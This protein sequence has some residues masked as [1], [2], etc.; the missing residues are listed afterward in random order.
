MTRPVSGLTAELYR[1][2]CFAVCY[3]A[4]SLHDGTRNAVKHVSKIPFS[5]LEKETL[6]VLHP[7]FF[8]AS[9]LYN[10]IAR[11]EAKAMKTKKFILIAWKRFFP[12]VCARIFPLCFVF[13][14]TLN[15][16]FFY[17]GFAYKDNIVRTYGFIAGNLFFAV[18]CGLALLSVLRR[19]RPP[20]HVWLLLGLVLA[21]YA[22]CFTVGFLQL[23]F[24]GFLLEYARDFIVFALPAFFAGIYGALER[25]ERTFLQT[26][27]S[28]SFLVLPGALIYANSVIFNC[29]PWQYNSYLGILG[30]MVVAYTFMPYLLAL[31]LRFAAGDPFSWRGK[32]LCHPQRVRGLMIA[33]LWVAII[34]TATRGAFVSILLFCLTLCLSRL[35]HRDR[36]KPA[37]WVSLAM[38]GILFFNL[39]IY[40]PPGLYRLGSTNMFLN[41]LAQ[42]ELVTSEREDP[43]VKEYIDDL[44]SVDGRIQ[45]ANREDPTDTEPGREEDSIADRNFRIGSRGTLFKLALLEFKKSPITGMGPGSYSLKYGMYPHSVFL[46]LLCE[47]GLIGSL[48]LLSLILYAFIRL[49]RAGWK[50]WQIRSVLLFVIA[51]AVQANISGCLWTCAPLL[52]ALG[53]GI[54]CSSIKEDE[55]EERT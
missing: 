22:T 31:L 6:S 3:V 38:T 19:R 48:I 43:T 28:C 5:T 35:L 52:C 33:L 39:F 13:S 45:V 9:E 12:W 41:Y 29:L 26:L 30:Y 1:Y 11:K 24:R 18:L 2:H 34:A 7:R 46:E 27:E 32:E 36:T 49:L 15:L 42:G 47:T 16:I 20:L 37:A 10:S 44:V 4:F 8:P 17:L 40:A 14:S 21:F 25:G 53:Y 51:Y 23:G 50:N 55:Q 54:A